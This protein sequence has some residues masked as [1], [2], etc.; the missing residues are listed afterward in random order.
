MIGGERVPRPIPRR[1][2]REDPLLRPLVRRR[3]L[4][5]RHLQ[6][7]ALLMHPSRLATVDPVLPMLRALRLLARRSEILRP[8]PLDPLPEI[9]RQALD[10]L[11]PPRLRLPGRS[12][13][14]REIELEVPPLEPRDR[15]GAHPREH[16]QSQLSASPRESQVRPQQDPPVLKR[17]KLDVRPLPPRRLQ[18][19]ERMPV[20][21]P[22]AA[23]TKTPH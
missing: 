9:R 19:G 7:G 22:L 8:R 1:R 10:Q 23:P 15:A 12:L 17:K 11:P 18:P 5:S 2:L 21:A 13:Y 6:S 3:D 16:L 4:Q 20:D 14:P